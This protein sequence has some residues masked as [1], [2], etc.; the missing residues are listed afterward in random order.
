MSPDG[1]HADARIDSHS[2]CR[3][4]AAAVVAIQSFTVAAVSPP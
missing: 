1:R 3:T 4:I 2:A